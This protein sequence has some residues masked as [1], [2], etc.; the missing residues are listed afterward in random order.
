MERL[1]HIEIRE[2]LTKRAN[3]SLSQKIRWITKKW[4]REEISAQEMLR[5][6]D[7]LW[8][9]LEKEI[10]RSDKKQEVRNSSQP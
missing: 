7:K 6:E 10:L 8:D 1:T 3:R 9:N 5:R 4:V 2:R